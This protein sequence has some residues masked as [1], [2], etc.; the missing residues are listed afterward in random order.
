MNGDRLVADAKSAALALVREDYRPAFAAPNEPSIRV[1]GEELIAGAKLAIHMMLRGEYIS[2][3]DAHVARKLANVLAGGPLTESQLVTEQYLPDL[4]R[5]T[6]L[7]PSAERKT[8]QP[9]SPTPQP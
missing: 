6:F 7:T 3:Y 4:E 2:E 5:Q 9:R 8:H 1:L